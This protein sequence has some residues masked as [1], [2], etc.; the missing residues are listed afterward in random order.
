MT[1]TEPVHPKPALGPDEGWQDAPA[2]V[3]A[4]IMKRFIYIPE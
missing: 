3:C 4:R 2:A 1:Q